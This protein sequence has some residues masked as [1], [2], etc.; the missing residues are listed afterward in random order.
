MV[1]CRI[2]DMGVDTAAK[3]EVR[4]GYLP[5]EQLEGGIAKGADQWLTGKAI[6]LEPNE[7]DV[8]PM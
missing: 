3:R 1:W 6:Q 7:V 8:K 5:K 2:R 4:R